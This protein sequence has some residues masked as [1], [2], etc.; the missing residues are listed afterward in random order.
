MFCMEPLLVQSRMMAGLIS[1]YEGGT[2]SVNLSG[3]CR[4]ERGP[5]LSSTIKSETPR[6][7]MCYV[8]TS[9]SEKQA[10]VDY[11]S[12]KAKL[13]QSINFNLTYINTT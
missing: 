9:L 2:S 8:G 12:F 10:L 6:H 4:D 3:T 7:S 13:Q 1:I 5:E 11:R